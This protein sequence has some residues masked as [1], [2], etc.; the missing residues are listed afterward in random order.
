MYGF[1]NVTNLL[2]CF[3]TV[4]LFPILIQKLGIDLE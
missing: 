2:S 3:D 1:M 4:E